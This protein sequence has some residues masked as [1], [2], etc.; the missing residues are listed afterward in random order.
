MA[1]GRQPP[2]ASS[3]QAT[4]PA[5][6]APPVRSVFAPTDRP[7]EPITAGLPSGPGPGPSNVESDYML[8]LQVMY[9]TLPRAEIARLMGRGRR[10]YGR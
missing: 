8:V 10:S 9:E 5:M 4:A 2:D 7:G 6:G 1:D 3:P